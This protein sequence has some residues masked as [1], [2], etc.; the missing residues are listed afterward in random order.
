[1]NTY[2]KIAILAVVAVG[3]VYGLSKIDLNVDR[4]SQGTLSALVAQ[5]VPAANGHINDYAGVLSKATVEALE[6]DLRGF[7]PEIA[8]LTVKSMGGL[9]IE[10]YGIKVAEAWKVGSATEDDGIILIVSTGD[11]K[12]RIEVGYGSESKI[13]DA[14][15]GR[16]LDESVLP[17]FKNGDWEGGIL[18][19][20]SAIKAALK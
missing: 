9:T 18:G 1:M 12:V 3:G 7:D 8:V 20:V 16:I 6:A 13:N 5:E 19:G 14:K 15:A 17:Q 10:E 11:R 4:S 2:I